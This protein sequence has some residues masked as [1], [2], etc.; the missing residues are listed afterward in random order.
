VGELGTERA[1]EM[2]RRYGAKYI[3]SD[4]D[5]P[6]ALTPLYPNREHPNDTYVV[7]AVEN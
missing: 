3:V 7:Y 4:Q 1:I 6:L 5:H 2:A